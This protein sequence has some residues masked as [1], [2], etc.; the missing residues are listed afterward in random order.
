MKC[1]HSQCDREVDTSAP[2][3]IPV[4]DGSETWKTPRISGEHEIEKYKQITN[5]TRSKQRVVVVDDA[6]LADGYCCVFCRWSH[7]KDQPCTQHLVRCNRRAKG[8][9]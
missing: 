6:R 3:E 1:R 8:L 9:D 2:V 4:N 5:R 7:A